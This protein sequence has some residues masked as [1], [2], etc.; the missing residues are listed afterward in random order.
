MEAFFVLFKALIALAEKIDPILGAAL[1]VCCERMEQWYQGDM[2]E[3]KFLH[4]RKEAQA[5]EIANLRKQIYKL[6]QEV[7]EYYHLRRFVEGDSWFLTFPV[8]WMKEHKLQSVQVLRFLFP[9]LDLK[10]AKEEV[11]RQIDNNGQLLPNELTTKQMVAAANE[12]VSKG[13]QPLLINIRP[14]VAPA[15]QGENP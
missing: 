9:A 6:E 5:G 7:V 4:E 8:S 15:V 2:E 13:L 12:L 3:I 14:A 11:E 1:K 10:T